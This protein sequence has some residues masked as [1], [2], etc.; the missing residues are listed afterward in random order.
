MNQRTKAAWQ[1]EHQLLIAFQ[2]IASMTKG[3]TH[4]EYVEKIKETKHRMQYLAQ[5]L[6]DEIATEQQE[7]A[8]HHTAIEYV[9]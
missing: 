1:V 6:K 3:P 7:A 5:Q 4:D 9:N 8:Y 2:R